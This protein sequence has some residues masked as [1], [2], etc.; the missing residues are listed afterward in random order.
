MYKHTIIS[1]ALMQ[2]TALTI[3]EESDDFEDLGFF[4][5]PNCTDDEPAR[6]LQAESTGV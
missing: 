2:A 5:V 1:L 4:D 6:W 3:S